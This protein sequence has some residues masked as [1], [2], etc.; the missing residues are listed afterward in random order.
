MNNKEELSQREQYYMNKIKKRDIVSPIIKGLRVL[1]FATLVPCTFYTGIGTAYGVS[2]NHDANQL[3]NYIELGQEDKAD[4]LI[5]DKFSAFQGEEF[6]FYGMSREQQ[7]EYIKSYISDIAKVSLG[8]ISASLIS[9]LCY[10]ILSQIEHS[11]RVHNYDELNDLIYQFYMDEK[12]RPELKEAFSDKVN[13]AIE[14]FGDFAPDMEELAKEQAKNLS[15]EDDV[16]FSYNNDY[17]MGFDTGELD[18]WRK[19]HEVAPVSKTVLDYVNQNG[20]TKELDDIVADCSYQK[21]HNYA[22]DVCKAIRM[23]KG[24]TL[25][26]EEQDA[27]FQE[28]DRPLEDSYSYWQ[29]YSRGYI[30]M[31]PKVSEFATDEY[32]GMVATLSNFEICSVD[33][34]RMQ[35]EFYRGLYNGMDEIE[36]KKEDEALSKS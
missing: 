5:K 33:G 20:F 14:E 13:K 29:G 27:F 24:E 36:Y 10:V 18:C 11:R 4:E 12:C 23:E 28:H 26:E 1:A 25:P 3:K 22:A 21:G 32:R 9:M 6:D 31:L 7:L 16:P 35:S 30:S 17:K 8:C 34:Y 2:L 15:F 19:Y